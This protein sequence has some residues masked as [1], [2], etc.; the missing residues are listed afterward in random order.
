M[1]KSIHECCYTGF[2][3]IA[4]NSGEGEAMLIPIADIYSLYVCPPPPTSNHHQPAIQN[5]DHGSIIITTRQ[6]DV[7]RPLWYHANA[8]WPGYDIIDIL[9]AFVVIQRVPDDEYT[10]LVQQSTGGESAIPDSGDSTYRHPLLRSSSTSLSSSSSA[11]AAATDAQ[12]HQAIRDARFN[13]LERF[14]RIT[15]FSRD[16]AG[17]YD[18]CA[19]LSPTT[20]DIYIQTISSRA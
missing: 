5:D 12:L 4:W 7:L 20:T 3:N 13:I 2:P 10:Y 8:S 18:T 9:G 14:S 6:G 15:R 1:Y 16:T 17:K 19:N 11:A